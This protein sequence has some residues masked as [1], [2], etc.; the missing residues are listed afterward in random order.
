MAWVG[1]SRAGDVKIKNVFY[2]VG[3]IKGWDK[4]GTQIQGVSSALRDL[5]AN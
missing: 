2:Q 4:L 5:G 1:E 3:G